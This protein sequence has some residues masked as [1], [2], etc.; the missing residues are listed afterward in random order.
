MAS[1]EF[2]HAGKP[3]V[4]E[5]KGH[6]SALLSYQERIVYTLREKEPV[7]IGIRVRTPYGD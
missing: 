5:L 1:P 3:L 2:P 6:D 4:G 7:V